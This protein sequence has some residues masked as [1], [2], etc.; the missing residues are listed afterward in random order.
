MDIGLITIFDSNN[1]GNKL[2]NFAAV[3]IIE[4]FGL[5]PYTLII[6][7]QNNIIKTK[8][9]MLINMLTGYRLSKNQ[10][11]WQRF[12]RFRQFDKKYLNQSQLLVK[13][14]LESDNFDYFI[15]GS[16]QV[17]NPTW[18]KYDPIRKNAFL[19]TFARPEQKICMAPS[20]GISELPEEW[21]VYFK[22]CLN[23]F[24]MLSVREEDGAKIIKEL[25]GRDAQVVI[26]PTLMLD[27]SEWRKIEKKPKLNIEKPYIVKCFLG[28]QTQNNYIKTIADKNG[29][30]IIDVLDK[31]NSIYAHCGPQEFLY[32]IDHAELV[33]TDSFHATVFS[34][35]FK[36][37]FLEF[38][39]HIDG[40]AA[41]NSRI[42]TLLK[43]LCL[44]DRLPGNVSDEDIFKCDYSKAYELLETERKKSYDFLK[45]SFHITE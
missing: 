34:I 16:D 42:D 3:K 41:M 37:P 25:T 40:E 18:Y 6:H 19:L 15:I 22:E 11:S 23:T 36:K 24:P 20:F 4:S 2:Q 1:Y 33:C 13:G 38:Y 27:S 17:W 31:S 30:E 5:N 45:K 7:K 9:K 14:K 28:N 12:I 8:I 26:D 43:K 39:R 32:L 10:Y 44:E 35:L 21:K 29:L